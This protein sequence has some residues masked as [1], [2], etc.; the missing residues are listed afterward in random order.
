MADV[1]INSIP[2]LLA[3]A[4]GQYGYGSSNAYLSVELGA[5]LDFAEYDEHYNFAGCR[6]GNWYCHFDGKGHTIDNIRYEGTNPW[7]FFCSGYFRGSIK[8]L[9]LTNVYA[10]TTETIAGLVYHTESTGGD[11]LIQNCHVSG[12]LECLGSGNIYV[13]GLVH[14]I[15]GY[16]YIYDSSFSGKFVGPNNGNFFG[17]VCHSFEYQQGTR[18]YAYNCMVNA[19][20]FTPN[21][22]FFP[23]AG[24]GCLALNCEFKGTV[25][26]NL[27][28]Y[29]AA[30]LSAHCILVLKGDSV[31]T[32]GISTSAPTSNNVFIDS[33]ELAIAGIS[34][35]SGATMSGATTVQ[36]KDKA[37]LKSK[38]F[39]V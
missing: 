17:I 12:Q 33:D 35:P 6:G 32:S 25:K 2:D 38:G 24:L 15:H 31:L 26:A 20:S 27:L 21:A 30:V 13:S 18:N 39:A 19:D 37:W 7:A 16:T 23:I 4:S 14:N 11:V 3:F 28:D 8:N 5:D 36:L 22:A 29:P 34:I 10:A 1:V 9:N